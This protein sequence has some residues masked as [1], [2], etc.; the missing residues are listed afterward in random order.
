MPVPVPVP[1]PMPVPVLVLV[2]PTG[3][4][5]AP[6]R[7]LA[8][9]RS[10]RRKGFG[11]LQLGLARGHEQH[12]LQALELKYFAAINVSNESSRYI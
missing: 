5:G 7:S 8:R 6:A 1:M 3:H 4:P 12:V 11:S 2:A 10:E 9:L